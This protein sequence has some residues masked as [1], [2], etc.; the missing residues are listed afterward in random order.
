MP[1]KCSSIVQILY[2][3]ENALVKEIKYSFS[4]RAAVVRYLIGSFDLEKE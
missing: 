2:V 1:G 3:L 4:A